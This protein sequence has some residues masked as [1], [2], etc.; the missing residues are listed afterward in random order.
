M[1]TRAFVWLAGMLAFAATAWGQAAQR[2]PHIGY[3][4][5]AGGQQGSAIEVKVG[6]QVLRGVTDAYVSA[7]RAFL[8]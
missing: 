7:A 3:V 4:F 6:G 2:A 8:K 5:P 1:R